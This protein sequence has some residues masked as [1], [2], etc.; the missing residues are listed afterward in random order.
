MATSGN[1]GGQSNPANAPL[2]E[3]PKKVY[4]R[5]IEGFWRRVKTTAL[6]VLLGIFFVGPWIPWPREGMAPDQAIV[7]HMAGRR[8]YI[9]GMEF[10]PQE[11]YYITGLLVIG[12]VGLFLVTAL[13][14][15]IWC[16]FTCPQTVWTDLFH[17]IERWI[18]GDRNKRIKLDRRPWHAPDRLWR[19]ALKHAIYL[20]IAVLTATTIVLYFND[21][22]TLLGRI[23]TLQATTGTYAVL[24]IF[25]VFTYLLAA[26]AR[27]QVCIYMCPWPRFQ[28]AMFDEHSRIVTYEAWRGEPRGKAKPGQSFEGRGHCVDCGMC[29]QVCPTGVDIREGNQ[30]ACI[31]C[32]LCID[33]CNSIMDRF[34]LP[35]GLI[36]YDSIYNQQVRSEGGEE[37]KVPF[38]RARTIGYTAVLAAVVA[39]MGYALITRPAMSLNVLHDRSPLFVRM[40]D[41]DIKNGY[42]FKIM[43]KSDTDR[44]YRLAVETPEGATMRVVGHPVNDAKTAAE[45][46]VEEGTVGSFRVFVRA[47]LG[48]LDGEATDADFVLTDLETGNR[49]HYEGLFSGPRR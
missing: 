23:V 21:S 10:W 4:P 24:A 31:G 45:L 48:S 6:T 15:R 18:E 38:W 36:T 17:F 11:V 34:G 41:G 2:Y 43:N 7:L 5:R 16:G 20:V 9:F 35:R 22:P 30:L 14:G 13:F 1:S 29:W 12:A 37:E 39:L 46:P 27:E 32:A 44:A 3:T 26:L 33:A 47:P 42:T 49:I 25:T 28:S 8:A 19:K 40:A